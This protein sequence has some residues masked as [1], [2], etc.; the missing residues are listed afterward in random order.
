MKAVVEATR[1]MIQTMVESGQ[2]QEVQGPKL[3][4][5]VLKQPQF[6]WEVADKYTEWKAFILEVRNMLPTYNACK[7]EKITVVKNRLGRKGLHYIESLTEGEKQVCGTL[8]GLIDTLAEKFR[9]QYS[10]TITS[11]PFRKLCRSEGENAEEWMGRLCVVA[12]ECN[13]KEID[14]QL[15]EQFIHG[16]NNKTMLDKVIRELTTKNINQQTT[17][18]Y[19]LILAKRVGA[20]KVHAAILSDIT[21]SQKFYKVKV[22]KKPAMHSASPNQPCRYCGSSHVLRQ[23]P[24]YGKTCASCRQIGHFKKVCQSRKDHAVHEVGVEMALEEGIIEE[25]GINSVYLNNKQLLITAQLETQVGDNVLKVL[26]KIDTGSEGNL[27]LL[28]IFNKLF[29][30]E[31]VEQLKKSIKSNIKLKTYNGMQIEQLGMCVVTIKF[32][33]LKK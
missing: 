25:V 4:G 32:K 18:E 23:C 8:Q 16:L 26:H 6:N 14:H 33:N 20:Q 1:A 7:Q 17:S 11:L 13:Y 29:R 22:A 31:L 9:P 19:M 27:M 28:Y 3:G 5:P 12:A 10:E 21:K 15:K 30:N 2:R 24:A